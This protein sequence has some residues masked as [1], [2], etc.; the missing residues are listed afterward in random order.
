MVE[1]TN[2]RVHMYTGKPKVLKTL[3]TK[4]GKRVWWHLERH[5]AQSLRLMKV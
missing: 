4:E 2:V 3:R 5:N 1:K